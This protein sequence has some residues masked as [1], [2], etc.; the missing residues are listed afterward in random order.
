MPYVDAPVLGTKQPAEQGRLVVL[1][2][3]PE[4]LR[5][6][7]APVFDAVGQRTQWVAETAGAGS[8]VEL[9]M[10][11]WVL[12]VV[13]AVAEAVSLAQGLGI[14]PQL[15]FDTLEGGALDCPYVHLKGGAMLRE[16]FPAAFPA[17]GA[18][19]DSGL[20]VDAAR[21]CGVEPRVAAAVHALFERT[22]DLGHGDEDMAAAWYAASAR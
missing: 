17:A 14:D 11:S 6:R 8:R 22:V 13:G 4:S 15:F 19:K 2:S 16:E 3:G 5:D 21:A 7:C 1:A 10:S 9:V 12:A 20:I 18:K